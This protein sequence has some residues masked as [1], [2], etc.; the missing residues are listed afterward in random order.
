MQKKYELTIGIPS[1][2]NVDS[3]KRAIYS[4]KNQRCKV[5][6]LYIIVSEDYSENH[7]KIEALFLNDG[8]FAKDDHIKY[9]CNN[10]RLGMSQNWNQCLKLSGTKYVSLLHDDDYLLSDYLDYVKK[11]LDSREKWDCV[12]F[13]HFLERNGER[14]ENDRSSIKKLLSYRLGSGKIRKLSSFE[15]LCGGYNYATVPTCG[16]LF[17]RQKFLDFGG[18]QENDGYS[19]DEI[20]IE[21]FI[22]HGHI[23]LQYNVNVGVYSYTSNTNLSSQHKIKKCFVEEHIVHCIEISEANKWIKNLIIFLIIV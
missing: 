8:E 12:V 21:R 18:Y 11:L 4:I 7:D 1:Y 19:V 15:Y 14:M 3:L 23:V 13:S 6:D 22:R 17:D 2:K 20:F 9:Y 16:I 10:P 5:F